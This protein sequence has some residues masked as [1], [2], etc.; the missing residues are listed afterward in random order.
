MDKFDHRTDIF[1]L[2]IILNSV[3]IEMGLIEGFCFVMRET[4]GLFL[5][6][7]GVFIDGLLNIVI[8]LILGHNSC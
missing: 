6:V 7:I 2:K 1:F 3:S 4:S 8:I 5:K